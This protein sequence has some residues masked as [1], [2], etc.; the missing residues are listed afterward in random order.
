M[1]TKVLGMNDFVVTVNAELN[2]DK[3]NVTSEEYEPVVGDEGIVRS[4]QS[5][6]ETEE[7]TTTNPEGAPGTTS[8]IPQYEVQNQQEQSRESE[9]EVINY[10]INKRIEEYVQAPGNVERLSVS[11]M[12]NS[13]D[14]LS[15]QQ[16]ESIT[17]AVSTAVGYNEERG[18]EISVIGMPF[19]EQ[20]GAATGE[21]AAGFQL[22]QRQLLLIAI[23]I[24][25]AILILFA[26]LFL[27]RGRSSSET[28]EEID[29]MVEE[30]EEEFAATT[31]L[32]EEEKERQQLI[33]QLRNI[34][35]DQPEEIAELIKSWMGEG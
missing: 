5:S 9:E 25:A 29:Y 18:D 35:T 27:S 16:Q 19:A 11:V 30:A 31:E 20:M 22:T 14:D 12:V 26:V 24:I 28:T 13:E 21:S 1:L 32:S 10:E 2:F 15:T 23:G 17:Q 3:R 34:A 7:G 4:R 8:N 6:E 33:Q